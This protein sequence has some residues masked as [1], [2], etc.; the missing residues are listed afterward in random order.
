[1][2][3]VDNL[4]CT[5]YDPEDH[6]W[7]L[8]LVKSIESRE[9]DRDSGDWLV[10]YAYDTKTFP[11]YFLDQFETVPLDG[12]DKEKKN[13]K[14]R[15]RKTHYIQKKERDKI[16]KELITECKG[17]SNTFIAK[18]AMSEIEKQHGTKS[19]GKPLYAETTLAKE[20]SKLKTNK[21]RTRNA[22]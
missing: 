11:Q 9:G 20:V 7:Y 21:K 5:R 2:L 1:L 12:K 10:V 4:K 18:K 17:K 6:K 15:G 19:N 8:R 14:L 22:R 16:L 3:F 13:I